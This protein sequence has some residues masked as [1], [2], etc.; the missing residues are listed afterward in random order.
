MTRKSGGTA[1]ESAPTRAPRPSGSTRGMFPGKPPPVMWQSARTLSRSRSGSPGAR[2]PPGGGEEG[3][4][5]RGS[6]LRQ[7]RVHAV[8]QGLEEDLA[9]EGVT[10]GVKPGRR[11]A[12]EDVAF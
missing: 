1:Q 6:E 12:E 10:V 11:E 2:Y 5:H 4:S 9:G 3:L 8:A 7:T